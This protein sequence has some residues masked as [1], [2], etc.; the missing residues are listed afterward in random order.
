[1][2]PLIQTSAQSGAPHLCDRWACLFVQEGGCSWDQYRDRACSR[3]GFHTCI[4]RMFEV[5]GGQRAIL[6]RQRGTAR[7]AQLVSVQSHCQI[8][9]ACRVEDSADLCRRESNS[10]AVRVHSIGQALFGCGGDHVFT[11]HGNVSVRI[12]SMLRRERVGREERRHDP[13]RQT[14]RLDV[15]PRAAYG[16]HGGHPARSPT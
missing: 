6:G 9:V 3:Q 2:T 11:D 13:H 16:A 5:I 14:H 7:V 4:G 1:M 15:G 8:G 10:F 12:R